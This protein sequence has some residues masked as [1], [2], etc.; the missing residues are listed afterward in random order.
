VSNL[1]LP[2]GV[3]SLLLQLA[4]LILTYL[5]L[6]FLKLALNVSLSFNVA[7]LLHCFIAGSCALILRFDW[8]W[9]VIQFFFPL[10]VCFFYSQNIPSYFYLFGLFILSLLY[11]STYRTQVPYFPSKP[12][13]IEPIRTLLPIE[14]DFAFID[15]GS[16]MGGLVLDLS[17]L[18][19]FGRFYGVEIAPLPWGISVFRALVRKIQVKF[20]FGSYTDL[21]LSDY[22]VVFCYL[23]PA[24]MPA[25]WFKVQQEMR[26]GTLF[27]SYEFIVPGVEPD[28]CL[29][30]ASDSA[31]LYG[32]RI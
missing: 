29:E 15:L 8:W 28:L 32:W 20:Y 22:D 23:S 27:L 18:N 26:P 5:F 25:L 12:S 2:I 19:F 1:K 11:W 16:G 3:R 10:L 4:S 17:R 31:M 21:N 9:S 14:R 7:L 30:T 24:A 6:L 13:L